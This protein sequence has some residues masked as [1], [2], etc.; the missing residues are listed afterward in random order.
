MPGKSKEG[1]G[2]ET[3]PVYKKSAFTMRSGNSPL[4][5]MMG[6]S[7]ARDKRSWKKKAWDKATQI[8]MGLKKGLK[9]FV[10]DTPVGSRISDYPGQRTV[11]AFKHGYEE[12]KKHDEEAAKK[13]R[14][15]I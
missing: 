10:T 1:G 12:E 9:E 6:S 7:P 3:S 2:L 15:N 11:E 4:F 13:R 8:G 14:S 5:K